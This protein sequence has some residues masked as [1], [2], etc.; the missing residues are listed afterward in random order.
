MRAPGRPSSGVW[1]GGGCN[2][3]AITGVFQAGH[4]FRVNDWPPPTLLL[5]MWTLPLPNFIPQCTGRDRGAR[6]AVFVCF[7]KRGASTR[8]AAQQYQAGGPTRPFPQLLPLP[9]HQGSSLLPETPYPWAS[10]NTPG[11]LPGGFPLLHLALGGFLS[12]RCYR[13]V[14]GA[15][16]P[17]EN[18]RAAPQLPRVRSASP[19]TQLCIIP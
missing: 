14:K 2:K 19:H 1:L 18:G 9:S 10:E 15:W 12:R 17:T 11:L 5:A 3:K 4:P 7:L 8:S 6:E 13:E 16:I